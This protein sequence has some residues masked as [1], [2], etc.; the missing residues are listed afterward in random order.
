M[1]QAFFVA[2]ASPRSLVRDFKKIARCR[3]FAPRT[4]RIGHGYL[5]I[6]FRKFKAMFC[7]LMLQQ[8]QN[9]ICDGIVS[10][11]LFRRYAPHA[12]LSP[13]NAPSETLLRQCRKITDTT[14]LTANFRLKKIRHSDACLSAI[15]RLHFTTLLQVPKNAFL[16]QI[17]THF[18]FFT[19][20]KVKNNCNTVIPYKFCRYNVDKR[21][22]LF[23]NVQA[24]MIC[25]HTANLGLWRS[26]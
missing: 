2:H 18:V 17:F 15:C 20:G 16:G 22:F 26:W 7:L 12:P 13:P 6:C 24:Q 5:R 23:Y 10:Q 14:F 19:T 1:F 4:Q 21:W 9:V 11:S 8:M 3:R 25:V